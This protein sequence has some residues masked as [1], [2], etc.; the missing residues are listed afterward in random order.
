MKGEA[1]AEDFIQT[2]LTRAPRVGEPDGLLTVIL[3]G[4]NAWEWYKKDIDGKAFLHAFYRKLSVLAREHR[5]IT[6]YDLGVHRRE[7]FAQCSCAPGVESAAHET[8][9][10]WILDQRQFR[11]VDRGT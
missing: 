8:T 5:V 2:I 6:G 11:Y 7:S 9:L 3:D 4:E 10:A 1:A